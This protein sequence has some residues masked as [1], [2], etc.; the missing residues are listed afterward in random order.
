MIVQV[1]RSAW[2]AYGLGWIHLYDDPP[3]PNKAVVQTGLLT[4]DG[5]KKPGYFAFKA[6]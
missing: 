1:G 6:G 4:Y 2:C 5:K 3:N